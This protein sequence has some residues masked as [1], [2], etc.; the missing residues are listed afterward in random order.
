MTIHSIKQVKKIISQ[1]FPDLEIKEIILL[2]E[3]DNNCAYEIN[4]QYIFRFPKHL[5]AEKDLKK[6]VVFLKTLKPHISLLIPEFKFV[7]N[8][9]FENNSQLSPSRRFGFIK[10]ILTYFLDKVE[11]QLNKYY[12]RID[13]DNFKILCHCYNRV[14]VGYKKILGSELSLD[15]FNNIS[16]QDKDHLAKIL[17]EFLS[18]VHHFPVEEAHKMGIGRWDFTP[19]Y[20]SSFYEILREYVLPEISEIEREILLKFYHD[21]LS[22]PRYYQYIPCLIHGDLSFDHIIF[23]QD[24]KTVGIIDFGGVCVSD[25]DYDFFLIY[26]DYGEDFSRKLFGYYGR[27]FTPEILAKFNIISCLFAASEIKVGKQ[28]KDSY[29]YEKGW[30]TVKKVIGYLKNKNNL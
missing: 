15:I 10:K 12:K 11:S 23:S 17:A 4:N 13:L 8:G 9:N 5:Q 16:Q 24:D 26:E 18:S 29:L 20:Y 6:E 21:Y 14:F 28:K 25:R 30:K 1:H 7:G 19:E 27:N 3:G 22:E 2:G